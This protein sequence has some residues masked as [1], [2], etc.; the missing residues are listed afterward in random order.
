[1]PEFLQKYIGNILNQLN[2]QVT[3]H[4]Q[5]LSEIHL[6]SNLDAEIRAN[7]DIRYIYI[8]SSIAIFILLIA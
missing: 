4:L 2:I 8:F 7:S 6:H 3:P 5:P 1:M